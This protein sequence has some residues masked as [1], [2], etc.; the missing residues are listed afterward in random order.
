M[1]RSDSSKELRDKLTR[2]YVVVPDIKNTI[3]LS[4]YINIANQMFEA[5]MESYKTNELEQSYIYLK[6]LSILLIERIPK[7]T[8]YKNSLNKFN[9]NFITFV[10]DTLENLVNKMDAIE[11]LKLKASDSEI[12][13][14][15]DEF[16]NDD[17]EKLE[18]ISMLYTSP[19]IAES[20]NIK[21]NAKTTQSNDKI[22]RQEKI[23]LFSELSNIN[24]DNMN[25][26]LFHNLYP[27]I[28]PLY[29]NE[30][31]KTS[32]NIDINDINNNGSTVEEVAPYNNLNIIEKFEVIQI[33]NI[34]PI[35]P[36]YIP[37][38]NTSLFQLYLSKNKDNI[39]INHNVSSLFEFSK[40][41]FHASYTSFLN[42]ILPLELY[43]S[44]SVNEANRYIL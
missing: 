5:G 43:M 27:S 39:N 7:H 35:Y 1:K 11:D 6:K 28:P 2:S 14:L 4:K 44:N 10:L 25:I 29:T 30:T 37:S 19:T 42:N 36:F 13:F 15:S 8:E 32:N 33:L 23:S 24:Y 40:D 20:S 31:N 21:F 12:K 18:N 41:D 26:N 17:Y 3:S 38:P 22:F 34:T 9:H 16:D